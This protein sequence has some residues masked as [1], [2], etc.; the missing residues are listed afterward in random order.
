MVDLQWVVDGVKF[1]NV[2]TLITW[3]LLE[4]GGMSI[5]DV[6]NKFVCFSIDGVTIFQMVKSGACDHIIVAK[7][8]SFYEW[9]ALHG[10]LHQS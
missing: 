4:F 8:C 10:T 1:N 6:A 9:C 7:L 2:T 5:V 3:N